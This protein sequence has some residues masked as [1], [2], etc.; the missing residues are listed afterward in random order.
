MLYHYAAPGEN[1]LIRAANASIHEDIQHFNAGL[2]V[3][4]AL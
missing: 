1:Q 4:E 2:S 3:D